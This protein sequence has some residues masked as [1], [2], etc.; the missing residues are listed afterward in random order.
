MTVGQR[1]TA[2][3]PAGHARALRART[4]TDDRQRGRSV[5]GTALE[6]LA[7]AKG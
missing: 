7:P 3:D 4:S 2:A 1:L 5:I 6:S